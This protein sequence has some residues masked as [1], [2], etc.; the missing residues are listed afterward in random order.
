MKKEWRFWERLVFAAPSV[1]RP[2]SKPDVLRQVC[3]AASI[4]KELCLNDKLVTR[5][6]LLH[7]L[8]GTIFRFHERKK[9]LT[10]YID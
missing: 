10:A 4:Y 9:A 7:A 3:M 6:G 5:S 2:E 1:A 8:M